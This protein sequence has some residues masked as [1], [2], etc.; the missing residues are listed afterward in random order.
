[1]WSSHGCAAESG[2]RAI[3]VVSARASRVTWRSNIRLYPAATV[4][5]NWTAAAKGGNCVGASVQRADR[6][7]CFVNSWR[8]FHGG[9]TRPGVL[10]VGYH[11][12][13]SSSLCFHS[14]LQAVKR[15][16][17]IR[18][19][20][21][22]VIGYIRR[23]G[24]DRVAATDPGRRQEPFHALDVAGRG[25]DAR[26]HVTATNELCAGRHSDLVTPA[27]VAD[28]GANCVRAVTD[29]VARL[30]RIVPARVADTVM[31]RVMPFI[32]V[33]GVLA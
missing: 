7:G 18:R 17:F 29:V 9:T 6:V 10:C 31:D 21:P 22:G 30:S 19:T 14:S 3:S 2:I 24:W 23:F 33:I 20:M 4:S 1:M 16:T 11:H 27:V 28:H 5:C 13:T 15:T 8:I 12:D 25:A 26:V 32:V